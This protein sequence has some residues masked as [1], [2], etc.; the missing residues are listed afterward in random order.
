[1]S[2]DVITLDRLRVPVLVGGKSRRARL[3]I[4]RDGT[5]LL[6]AAPDVER[7]ELV[8]FLA[9]KRDWIYRKLAEKEELQLQPVQRELVL[10]HRHNGVKVVA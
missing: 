4:D 7:A 6:R 2:A 3:T 5:L 9:N 8:G 10:P 1:M